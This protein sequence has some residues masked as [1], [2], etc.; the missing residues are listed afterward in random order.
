MKL[1]QSLFLMILI[2]SVFSLKI[3]ATNIPNQNQPLKWEVGFQKEQSGTPS[4][5]FPAIVPGAVQLDFAKANDWPP[6]YYA[7]NWKEYG[8]MEDVYWTY[9]TSFKKPEI[10][11]EEQLFFVSKGIDYEFEI[12]LNGEKLFYQEGMFTPVNL[13][14]TEKVKSENE[15]FVRIFPAPKIGSFRVD[16]SQAAQSCKPAVSYGWDWHPRLVPLGIWDDTYLEIRKN[17]HITDLFTNY[18]LNDDFSEAEITVFAEGENL[19]GS[20]FEWSLKS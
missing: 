8:W 12:F 1:N 20:Q 15:L 2:L 16:R 11:T 5:W 14:I 18:V 9:K 4:D 19:K 17:I 7:E 10:A 3:H 6:L 13:N